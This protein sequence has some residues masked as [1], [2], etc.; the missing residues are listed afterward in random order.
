MAITVIVEMKARPGLRDELKRLLDELVATRGHGRRGFLG[1]ARYE[2]LD[3]PD[4]LVEIA[5]WDS[6]EARMEHL[7]EAMATNAFGPL[8]ELM[9]EPFRV[10][11]VSPLE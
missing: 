3:D 4:M 6:V 2:V 9:A 11:V 1:S 8:A 7:E 10:T 5:D